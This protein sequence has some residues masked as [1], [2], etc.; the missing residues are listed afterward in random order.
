M[1]QR[2]T[3]TRTCWPS[4]AT[5]WDTR[6]SLRLAVRLH[7]SLRMPLALQLITYPAALLI[8][9]IT[10]RIF[11]GFGLGVL[12]MGLTLIAFVAV[13]TYAIFRFTHREDREHWV[14]QAPPSS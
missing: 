3:T 6:C 10:M 4:A 2:A 11:D 9:I 5:T 13:S 1:T 7:C 12:A 14:D 8:A